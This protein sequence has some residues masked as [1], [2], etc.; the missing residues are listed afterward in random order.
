MKFFWWT[1]HSSKIMTALTSLT[2]AFPLFCQNIYHHMFVCMICM[3]I[4]STWILQFLCPIRDYKNYSK[5]IKVNFCRLH[6]HTRL[7]AL[8]SGT[9]QVSR[10]QKGKTNLDFTEARDSEWQWHKVGHMQICK[11]A[12]SSRQPTTRFNRAMLCIRGT[13]RRPV[14]VRRI[15]KTTPHDSPGTLVVWCQRSLRNSTGVTPYE[16]AECRWGGS[17]SATFDK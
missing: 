17:K 8:F 10:Y 3:K 12:P 9:T 4:T 11:S 13:S 1:K 7:T 2:C 6:T 5:L 15:T 14:S 16:A